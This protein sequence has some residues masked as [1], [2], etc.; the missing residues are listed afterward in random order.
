MQ[1][2]VISLPD[3]VYRRVKQR[4]Q[5]NQR[6]IADELV[7]V[8]IDALP[9]SGT[10]TA[11]LETELSQL[12]FLSDDDLWLAARVEATDAENER[13]QALLTKGKRIGL[14]TAEQEELTLLANFFRRVMLVRAEAAV[15]LKERGH[16]VSSLAF[17]AQP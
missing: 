7:S 11:D 17:S 5:Q 13:M 12:A 3:N 9:E 4:S 2:I 16:D 10:I 6:A 14:T 15:L 1:T 8:V